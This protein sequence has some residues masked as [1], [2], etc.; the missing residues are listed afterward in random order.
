MDDSRKKAQKT[1][2]SRP[3]CPPLHQ[4]SVFPGCLIY[5]SNRLG[6]PEKLKKNFWN[7]LW[8]CSR[9]KK[10]ALSFGLYRDRSPNVTATDL[11]SL[12]SDAR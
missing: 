7:K 8:A 11:L 5:I 4:P 12:F 10:G 2:P 9:I 3:A 6:S 1:R